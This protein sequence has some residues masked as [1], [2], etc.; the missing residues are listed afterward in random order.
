MRKN[1]ELT[2]TK[3]PAYTDQTLP[4]EETAAVRAHLDTCKRCRACAALFSPGQSAEERTQRTLRHFSALVRRRNI[5]VGIL[6]AIL[7]TLLIAAAY[8]GIMWSLRAGGL[9]ELDFISAMDFSG[10]T[11]LRLPCQA[12]GVMAGL[13]TDF[14]SEDAPEELAQRFE[15]LSDSNATYSAEL[16]HQNVLIHRKGADGAQAWYALINR[17]PGRPLIDYHFC[18]MEAKISLPDRKDPQTGEGSC[19]V[20]LCPYHLIQDERIRDSYG[21]LENGLLYGTT[22]QKEDFLAFYQSVGQYQIKETEQGFQISE[23][24][25]SSDAIRFMFYSINDRLYFS[26]TVL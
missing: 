17:T 6:A 5:T 25:N 12:E 22:Y 15:A 23:T 14:Y 20:F 26:M 3:L 21:G 7:A 19:A 10:G 9:Q 24:E 8:G 18:G 16:F 13:T 1:C 2:Q 4:E 11:E